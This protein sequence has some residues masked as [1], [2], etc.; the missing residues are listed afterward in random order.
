MSYF[1][2]IYVL[3]THPRS[4]CVSDLA[5]DVSSDEAL[6]LQLQKELDRES[7]A[8]VD[9]GGL[10]FCQLCQKDLSAM[11]PQLRTQHINRCVALSVRK[12]HCGYHIIV[13]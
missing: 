8:D 5:E 4:V 9:D 6:A 11:S 7:R 10:F 3:M 13:T 2:I 1:N 12:M